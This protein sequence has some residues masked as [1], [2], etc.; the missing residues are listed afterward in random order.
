VGMFDHVTC[1]PPMPDGRDLAKDSFQT[2]SL[3]CLMDLF[4]I[5]VAGRLIFRK[6]RYY[7]AGE[8]DERGKSRMPEPIADIDMNYHGDIEIYAVTDDGK[9]ASYAVRFTHGTLEW[10]RPFD[11][12]RESDHFLPPDWH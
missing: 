2:R 8:I 10:I 11:A 6:R 1:E 12:I 9:L 3:H 7:C 5:T 4:T